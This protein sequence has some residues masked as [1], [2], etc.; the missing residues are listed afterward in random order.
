[1]F[2]RTRRPLAAA[3]GVATAV[4][5]LTG[6]SGD[7]PSD[8]Q[9]DGPLIT[10]PAE[11]TGDITFATW[12]AYANQDLIDGFTEMYPNVNVELQF[13]AVDSY[14]TKIQAAASSGSLPDVFAA[15][16]VTL[17]GL[18]KA[19]QLYDMQEALGTAPADGSAASWGDAF[20]PALLAGANSG[21]DTSGGE[22]WGVPFNAISV[23]AIYNKDAYDKAGVTPPTTFGELLSTCTALRGAGYIPLSLTGKVW[24]TWWT[25]LAWDQTMRDDKAADF[26]IDNPNYIKGFELVKD[27]ADAGCWDE[28]QISTDIDAESSLFLQQ[29]TATF[30][31]VPEN[32]LQTVADGADFTLGTYVVPALGGVT[33]N[34]TLGGGNANVI[35]ISADSDNKSA[36]VA[37][38]KYLTSEAV[39]TRLAGEAF[40]IPSIQIAAVSSSPLMTAYIDAT[41]NGFTDPA[42]NLP[43]NTPEGLLKLQNEILPGLILGTLTPEQAA[44]A[45]ADIWQ[46]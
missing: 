29:R 27:M 32:F 42:S 33:P 35:V 39:A 28:S 24:S 5:L 31:S 14:P 20:V 37:F 11:V 8:G 22:V 41:A 38:A 45:S 4:A 18:Q 2:Q 36:A 25:S 26:S 3:I 40:T 34:H 16:N 44:Q 46:Q 21:M 15:Q 23:A 30:V 1:M 43:A 13:T 6:C 17:F 19:G 10:D 7:T 9:N 12:W